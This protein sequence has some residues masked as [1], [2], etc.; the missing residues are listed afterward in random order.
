MASTGELIDRLA[1]DARPVRRLRRPALRALAWLAVAA[2]LV[3]VIASLEGIRPGLAQAFD[4]PRFAIG[5]VAALATAITAALAAFELSVPD[6]SSR[7]LWLPLPFAALW[8]GAMGAGCIA[9]WLADGPSGLR[10][11]HSA[12]CFVAILTTSVPL[13]ALLLVMVR[14][15]GPVRPVATALAAGLALA[16]VGEGGLTLYHDVDATLMDLLIHLAA[17]AVVVALA[18]SGSRALFRTITPR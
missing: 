7:W 12:D 17:V 10:L 3:G 4:D 11:G 15:A 9:D 2:L 16:A 6:R 5:R 14:H 18:L 13:G 1:R 8:L